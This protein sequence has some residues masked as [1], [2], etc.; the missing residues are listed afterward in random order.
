MTTPRITRQD[1]ANH[2]GKHVAGQHPPRA[3]A[4][5]DDI[6]GGKP[7]PD[8]PVEEFVTP[9]ASRA[10]LTELAR[11]L[12][13]GVYEFTVPEDGVYEFTLEAPPFEGPQNR[14]GRRAHARKMRKLG[15]RLVEIRR[16]SAEGGVQ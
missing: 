3:K 4:I 7:E 10:G 6:W 15:R 12:G 11:T 9:L 2:F 1:A 5:L 16:V 8:E 14:Q 13:P